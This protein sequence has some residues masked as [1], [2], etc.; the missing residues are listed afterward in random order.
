MKIGFN[1]K[2]LKQKDNR[3]T[4]GPVEFFEVSI[5]LCFLKTRPRACE[6]VYSMSFLIRVDSCPFVVQFFLRRTVKVLRRYQPVGGGTRKY[7]RLKAGMR[8]SSICVHLCLSVGKLFGCS[9]RRLQIRSWLDKFRVPPKQERFCP[10]VLWR[11]NRETDFHFERGPVECA[12]LPL[13][14]PI[15]SRTR[16]AQHSLRHDRRSGSLGLGWWRPS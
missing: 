5:L 16:A 6:D 13:F 4:L 9:P 11:I 2:G 12:V 8:F 1:L 14:R 10:A 15:R 3:S 7:A